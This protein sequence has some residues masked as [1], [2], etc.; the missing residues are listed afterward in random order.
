PDAKILEQQKKGFRDFRKD[1]LKNTTH[2]HFSPWIFVL[3]IFSILGGV[4]FH[5]HSQIE[6]WL[7][8]SLF[9]STSSSQ[10]THSQVEFST[11]TPSQVPV[12]VE[13]PPPVDSTSLSTASPSPPSVVSPSPTPETTNVS[14]LRASKIENITWDPM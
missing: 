12:E 4:L 3:L 1:S 7:G 13:T 5:Q 6:K 11:P 10:S 8:F 14:T 2:R 9:T